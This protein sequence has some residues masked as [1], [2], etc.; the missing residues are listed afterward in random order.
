MEETTKS[1][2]IGSII[3]AD[4]TVE[5]ADQIRDFYKEVIGWGSEDMPMEDE[6]GKYN[7]YVMKT[8]EGN[9]VGG[10]CHARGTNKDLKPIWTIYIAV[11]DVSRS[12]AKCKDLG[13]K[14]LKEVKGEDG[15]FYYALI[16]DPA[17]ATLAIVPANQ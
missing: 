17:R 6:N 13:G 16:Q 7:D 12:V 8:K 11:E 5:N 14:V 9:W 3:S 1:I 10:V 4:L 15:T 2:S